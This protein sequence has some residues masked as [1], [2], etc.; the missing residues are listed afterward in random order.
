[1]TGKQA[2]L[3]LFGFVT[4]YE[5]TAKPGELL[6]EEVDRQLEANRWLTILFGV[7]TVAHL[8]NLLPNRIDPYH[9]LARMAN[10]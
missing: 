4:I 5:V 2:W 8:Y 7:V 1:M 6:S 3:L 9:W 10:R